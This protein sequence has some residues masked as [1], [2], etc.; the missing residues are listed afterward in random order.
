MWAD[1]IRIERMEN[2]QMDSQRH[3][4]SNVSVAVAAR[5]FEFERLT[6]G[7]FDPGTSAVTSRW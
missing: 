3:H 1:V 7:C 6:T 4:L 2:V 5:C